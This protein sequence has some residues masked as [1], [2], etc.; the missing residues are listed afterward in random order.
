VFS[1]RPPFSLWKFYYFPQVGSALIIS[2]NK[3][4][5]NNM[6]TALVSVLVVLLGGVAFDA[7]TPDQANSIVTETERNCT[8]MS[9]R[10]LNTALQIAM[11]RDD[12]KP[13][14]SAEQVY[15]DLVRMGYYSGSPL[16]GVS[17]SANQFLIQ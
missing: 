17:L 16:P 13:V 8:A 9:L 6:Q 3:S 10:Q 1:P 12:Y 7:L 11:L 4:R 14:G 2:G 15:I 5:A